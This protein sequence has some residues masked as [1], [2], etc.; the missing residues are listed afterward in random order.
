M[1][2]DKSFP[3]HSQHQT[4]SR[5][6]SGDGE[7]SAA[8]INCQYREML[9]QGT[10]RKPAITLRQRRRRLQPGRQFLGQFVEVLGSAGPAPGG[11]QPADIY[12]QL[13]T[14]MGDYRGLSRVAPIMQQHLRQRHAGRQFQSPRGKINIR[15]RVVNLSK[16]ELLEQLPASEQRR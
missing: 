9:L 16:S 5:Q 11:E 6:I 14:T 15:G 7:Q 8:K 13:L 10:L 1:R 2:F 3:H 12:G 4:K